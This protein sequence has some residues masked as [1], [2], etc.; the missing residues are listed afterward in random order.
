MKVMHTAVEKDEIEAARNA[1]VD[2]D[3]NGDGHISFDEWL[4]W[5][6]KNLIA[7]VAAL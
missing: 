6:Y 2:M 7:P 3:E 5:S 1:F 4:D